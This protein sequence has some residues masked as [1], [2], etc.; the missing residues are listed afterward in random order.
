MVRDLERVEIDAEQARAASHGIVFP[1]GTLGTTGDGPYALVD[2]AGADLVAV[3]E[4][5]G[6][7]C[8]P[9]VVLAPVAP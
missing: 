8:K 5:R 6:S 3:Y 9:A 4:R 2:T 7:A 1:S